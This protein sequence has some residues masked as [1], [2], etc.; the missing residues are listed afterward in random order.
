MALTEYS[1]RV[2]DALLER[3]P[4]FAPYTRSSSDGAHIEIRFPHRHRRF[5]LLVT[6]AGDEIIVFVDRDHQ[7]IATRGRSIDEDITEAKRFLSGL[8]S[9]CI[10]LA[11]DARWDAWTFYHPDLCGYDPEEKLEFT[12]WREL[13]I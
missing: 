12:R 9:G 10:L 13:A 5:D 3:F 4:E 11:K 2:R 8:L 1:A 7:H 6:T